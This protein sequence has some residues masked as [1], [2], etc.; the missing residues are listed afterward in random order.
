MCLLR[1]QH[2]LQGIWEGWSAENC[3]SRRPP[4]RWRWRKYPSCFEYFFSSTRLITADTIIFS[5]GIPS[6]VVEFAELVDSE[7][8]RRSGGFSPAGSDD[9][10]SWIRCRVCHC[11]SPTD[12]KAIDPSR[13]GYERYLLTVFPR[14]SFANPLVV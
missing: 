7:T 6:D 13:R 4:F 9:Q 3:R 1:R 8:G 10:F 14:P 5:E 2:D 12:V 11:A